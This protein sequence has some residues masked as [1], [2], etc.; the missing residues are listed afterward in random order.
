M[1]LEA[2]KKPNSR[3]WYISPTYRQSKTIAFNMIKSYLPKELIRKT[4]ISELSFELMNGSEIALKGAD[5]EDSL[6]GVALHFVVLDEFASMRASAWYEEIR[7]TL[8]DTGGKALFIGTPKGRNHFHDLFQKSDDNWEA[9]TFRTVDNPYI[10]QEEVDQ[11]KK[12]LPDTTFR[13]EYES[14]FLEDEIGV[15]K[16]I[17]Q[18][19]VGEL[20]PPVLGR[21]Y[22]MGVDLAKSVDFS[23][24]TVLDTITRQVVAFERFQDVAWSEQILR[25]QA[26]AHKYNDALTIVDST[27]VGDPIVESLQQANISLYYDK[28]KPGFKFNQ[29]NKFKLINT[30][31]I[32][33]E[34]RRITFPQIDVLIEELRSYEYTISNDLGRI[35]YNAPSGKHD[36]CVISLALAVWAIRSQL[37]EAQV[38]QDTEVLLSAQDKQGL[39]ERIIYDEPELEY[40]GY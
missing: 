11:A 38:V 39:G 18:C 8:S 26:L 14:A 16:K 4:N 30:L 28:D 34:Q 9:F 33:I 22:V 35:K 19:V 5:T 1:I 23:V 40:V 25:I 31:S 24:L 32:A 17:N 37:H 36:D 12:D 6:K 2:L 13:Q 27:G 15:F 7:P 10:P 29:D 20:Q 3:I 21:N